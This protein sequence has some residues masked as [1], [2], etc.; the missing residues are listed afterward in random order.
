MSGTTFTTDPPLVA[1]TGQDGAPSFSIAPAAVVFQV[2]AAGPQGVAGEGV[3]TGG[4]LGQVLTKDSGTDY[5]T[6]WQDV[7]AGVP[8]GGTAGQVLRKLSAV[9]GATEWDTLTPQ[10]VGAQIAGTVVR[11]AL[12][13]LPTDAYTIP[14]DVAYLILLGAHA[15]A[16]TLPPVADVD[17]QVLTIYNVT[18][19]TIA[20]D[21]VTPAEILMSGTDAYAL[22]PSFSLPDGTLFAL[23]AVDLGMF[24]TYWLP[25]VSSGTLVDLPYWPDGVAS[26]YDVLRISPSTLTPSW[27]ALTASEIP[28]SSASIAA[29]DVETGLEEVLDAAAHDP[30]WYPLPGHTVTTKVMRCDYAAGLPD[31]N[32]GAWYRIGNIADLTAGIDIRA[33]VRFEVPTDTDYTTG[34]SIDDSYMEILTQNHPAATGGDNFEAAILWS[35]PAFA[36]SLA[37]GRPHQFWESKPAASAG[38]ETL[39][40]VDTG[41]SPFEWVLLRWTV[42]VSTGTATMWRAVHYQ[43]STTCELVDGVW[44]YPVLT[45][46]D[47]DKFGD[48]ETGV[49]LDWYIG[50][51]LTG[52]I[53]MMRATPYGSSAKLIDIQPATLDALSLGAV[54]FAD[55]ADTPNTWTTT[56]GEIAAP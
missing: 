45:E 3:P 53:A 46:T 40:W 23:R 24:G 12:L 37:P 52:D 36:S 38:E 29:T 26:A 55:T 35:G 18:G 25:D 33:L 9:D 49:T 21:S 30:V 28:L 43:I 48:I 5:D 10:D 17:G 51:R 34:T 44:Y 1:F 15:G 6:S 47:L 20:Y 19:S 50:L 39:G 56:A 11:G 31:A 7:E 41:M 16:V 13:G 4:T 2:S 42:D 54:T 27:A 32:A 14:A 22:A 8:N